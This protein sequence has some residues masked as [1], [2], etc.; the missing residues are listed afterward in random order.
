MCSRSDGRTEQRGK[1]VRLEG[2]VVVQEVEELTC[3]QYG[4]QSVAISGHQRPLSSPSEA[5]SGHQWPSEG[6]T[7]GVTRRLVASSS[8]IQGRWEPNQPPATTS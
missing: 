8:E 7:T 6:L 1:S 3:M 5:I 4:K 2:V